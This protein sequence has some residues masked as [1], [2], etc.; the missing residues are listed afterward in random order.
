YAQ[1]LYLLPVSLFGMSISAAEL[2]EMSRAQGS[3]ADI[4][5]KLQERLRSGLRNVVF[6]VVPSMAAF[7][8]IGPTLVGAIFQSG[9]FQAQDTWEVWVILCGSA[10]GLTAGTQGR[11]LASAF[12]ALGDTK[13]PL[14]A[15]LV[16]V[17]LTFISGWAAALPL[18][19][20]YGYAPVYGAL[21]LTASAGVAAWIEFS[22]LRRWLGQRIGRLDLPMAL[23]GLATFAAAVAGVAGFLLQRTLS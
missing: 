5:A 21:G 4:A 20:H 9:R 23:L 12:Y 8:S 15:A 2:P 14:Y 1:T 19:A 13:T 17:V 10:V 16:R 3:S 6:L 18:R 11:L 7:I 22:L